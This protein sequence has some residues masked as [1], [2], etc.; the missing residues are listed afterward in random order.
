MEDLEIKNEQTQE[1]E[2]KNITNEEKVKNAFKKDSVTF[3]VQTLY[4]FMGV[5]ALVLYA[6]AKICINFGAMSATLMG[7]M[8]IF[9]YGLSFA[10]LVLAYLKDKQATFAV[11]IN[12]AVFL[13]ALIYM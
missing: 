2:D 10:G 7:I 13:I 5:C 4:A 6:I 8:S 11:G 1:M 9:I 12:L 3:N